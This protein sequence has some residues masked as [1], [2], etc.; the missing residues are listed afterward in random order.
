MFRLSGYTLN[1]IDIGID[2][3]FGEVEPIESWDGVYK[4]L[5]VIMEKNVHEK[6]IMQIQKTP[7]IMHG[8]VVRT[9]AHGEYLLLHATHDS[10]R[11]YKVN[12]VNAPNGKT[13][14]EVPF[15]ARQVIRRGAGSFLFP[16]KLKMWSD[17]SEEEKR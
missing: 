16:G 6:F 8:L 17:E 9:Q 4:K 14:V 15:M 5:V 3:G 11:Q 7:S 1:A 12:A 10:A 2:S 13:C